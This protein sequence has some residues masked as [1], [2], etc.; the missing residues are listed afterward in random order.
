MATYIDWY[1]RDRVNSNIE[2]PQSE[3]AYWELLPKVAQAA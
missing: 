1:N 2:D 3:Q